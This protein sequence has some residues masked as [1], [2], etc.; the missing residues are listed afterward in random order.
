MQ[1]P[2]GFHYQ[3]VGG[4]VCEVEEATTFNSLSKCMSDIAE[5]YAQN[6]EGCDALYHLVMEKVN[7]EVESHGVVY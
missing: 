4:K 7:E 6:F 2:A 5:Y 3:V 1:A